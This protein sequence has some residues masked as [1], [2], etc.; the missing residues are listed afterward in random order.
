M[1]VAIGVSVAVVAV[2]VV[3][4]ITFIVWLMKNHAGNSESHAFAFGKQATPSVIIVEKPQLNT[5]R[6]VNLAGA[7]AAANI[8]ATGRPAGVTHVNLQNEFARL[9]ARPSRRDRKNRRTQV[10]R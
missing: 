8:M 10:R 1:E 4:M 9:L 6:P 5:R 3:S 7:Q 2:V